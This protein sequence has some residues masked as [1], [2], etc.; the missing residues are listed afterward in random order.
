MT[1]KAV[2]TIT[3]DNEKN[4]DWIRSL[5]GYA[6]EVAIIEAAAKPKKGRAKITKKKKS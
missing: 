3:I 1:K 6:D 4:D 5:P 2:G